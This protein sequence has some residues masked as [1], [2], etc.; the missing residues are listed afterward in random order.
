MLWG[1]CGSS[2]ASLQVW[3]CVV[4]WSFPN[5]WDSGDDAWKCNISYVRVE[6]LVGKALLKVW[7]LVLAYLMWLVWW[8]RNSST[9]EDVVRPLDHLKSLL[10]QTLFDWS[11]VWGFMHRTSISDFQQY[12]QISIWFVCNCF[13]YYVFIIM[14]IELTFLYQWNFYYLSK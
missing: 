14:D 3:S 6:E 9:F 13:K 7:I 12:A 5:V 8:E 11:Q 2:F 4:E 1:N 10:I